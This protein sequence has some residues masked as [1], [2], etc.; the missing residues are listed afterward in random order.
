[1]KK[2]QKG[3]TRQKL[4]SEVI[5]KF[6]FAGPRKKAARTKGKARSKKLIELARNVDLVWRKNL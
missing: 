6:F 4:L 5:K 1:M 3:G 2:D